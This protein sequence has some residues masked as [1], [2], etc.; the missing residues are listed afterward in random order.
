MPDDFRALSFRYYKVGTT[1]LSLFSD[2]GFTALEGTVVT[3]SRDTE[4]A[5]NG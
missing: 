4:E 3:R 1:D 5:N 2:T